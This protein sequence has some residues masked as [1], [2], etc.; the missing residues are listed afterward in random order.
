LHLLNQLL[1]NEFEFNARIYVARGI[2]RIAASGENAVRFKRLLAVSA[3][4]AGGEYLSDKF[5]EFVKEAQVEV[6]VDNI[7]LTESG[8]VAADLTI[9][10]AGAAVK[11]N[12][13][14]RED[15][16]ELE[17]KSTDRSRVELAARLLRLAG[18]T[19]EVRREGGRDV[20]YVEVSTDKLAAGHVELRDALAE[21]VRAAVE[22]GWVDAG[23]AEGWLEKLEKGRVLEEGWPKYK[24]GLTHSGAL[25]V[26]Y[27]STNPDSI[28]QEA[29]RLRDMGLE[30]GV[31]FTVKMP[32]GG[33]KGYVSVLKEGLA[34]A[35]W[36]SIYGS[37][38]QQVLVA[39][40]V[41]YIL[42][43]AEEAGKEVYEK[44][45]EIVEEGKERGSLTLKGFEKEVEV[46][47]RKH[48]VKVIDGGAVKEDRDGRKLLRIKITA[49]VGGVRSD[50]VMTYGRYGKR[51]A[52]MGRATVRAGMEADAERFAAVIKALTGKEPRIYRMKDGRIMIEC[53]GGHLEGFMRYAEL[54]DAIEKWLEETR[55]R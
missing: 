26:I 12:V 37:G 44:V 29:Q 31:H 24:V 22:K 38:R 42:E 49:E 41:E 43:R 35:A 19:A 54:A 14:L 39:E 5:N 20:W 6:R 48:V 1:P 10:E 34:R 46:D 11:Y 18:V 40:F 16:I 7:R 36:L 21:I 53:Y 47:G 15:A 33:E 25:V 3:P 9:S 23:E 28:T 4:S 55:R 50:Y 27:R 2:Y 32:E 51:N 30:E 13:Y 17:F 45:R 52:A 8:Y